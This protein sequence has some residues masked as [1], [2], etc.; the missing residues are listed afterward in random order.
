MT[1]EEA[2]KEIKSW[3][4]LEGKEIEAIQTLIPELAESEDERIRKELIETINCMKEDHQVFL[5]EQ[6]IERYLDWLEKQKENPK[7]ADSI[8]SN[9]TS[10]AKCEDRDSEYGVFPEDA[11]VVARACEKLEAHGYLELAHALINVNL[12]TKEQKQ[13]W[14]E[15][16][17]KMK[18]RIRSVVNECAFHNDALDVN[19]DYCE[20]DYAK[21]DAWLK[22]LRPSWKPSEEDIKMLEHIIGQYETGNKNS[23]VMGYLPRVEELDFLKKVLAKWKN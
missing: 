14:S 1:R 15:E 21:L 19:G 18:E 13:E 11:L 22:S 16:D 12:Y 5:S 7:S 20:G 9:C 10:V 17:E 3:D 4:F 23:K 8:P 2:I 6:Q